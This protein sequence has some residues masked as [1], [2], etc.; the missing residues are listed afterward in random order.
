VGVSEDLALVKQADE[1]EGGANSYE[2]ERLDR[3]LKQL[4]RKISLSIRDR[5]W[6]EDLIRQLDE[7]AEQRG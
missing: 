4:E 6:V 3:L 5:A 7:R 1:H 2:A